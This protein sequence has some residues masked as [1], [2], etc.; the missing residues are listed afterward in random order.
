[1][2]NGGIADF[3]LPIADWGGLLRELRGF[4]RIWEG[5]SATKNALW[6]PGGIHAR[7]RAW[8][9]ALPETNLGIVNPFGFPQ[10]PQAATPDCFQ[11]STQPRKNYCHLRLLLA[12]ECGLF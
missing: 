11:T 6:A 3:R 2:G 9:R 1:M 10:N 12:G 8:A 7:R 4:T 5:K